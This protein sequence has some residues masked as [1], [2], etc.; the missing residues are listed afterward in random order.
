MIR[1]RIQSIA[2]H[3][4]L[5]AGRPPDGL[6]TQSEWARYHGYHSVRRRRD[7]L[8]G[9]WT[10]KQLVQEAIMRT[11]GFTPR[12]DSFSIAQEPG[13]APFVTSTCP[14]L[15]CATT[16]GRLPLRLS[17]SHS[18]DYALC[19]LVLPVAPTTALGVDIEVVDHRNPLIHGDPLS[20][21]ERQSVAAAPRPL[22][23]LVATAIWS[24]K[25][26]TAKAL[27]LELRDDPHAIQCILRPN[28][29]RTWQPFLVEICTRTAHND[30]AS[31][32][33]VYGWWRVMQC[34]LRPGRQY[35]VALAA[36]GAQ[37]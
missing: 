9:R 4:D 27:Q 5:A 6:L 32:A 2:D 34:R 30:E 21:D 11:A 14:A 24:A 18:Q 33:A 7:W 31:P 29:L 8:L 22:Q 36:Q 13:G 35:T 19:A 20:H 1:W 3:P 12:L 37:L 17:I 23:N 15:A 25:E 26:A 28:G 16:G 10:A